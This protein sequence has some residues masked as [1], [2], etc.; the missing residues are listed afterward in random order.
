M[1]ALLVTM[2]TVAAP[3]IEGTI[4]CTDVYTALEPCTN[5]IENGGIVPPSCCKGVGGLVAQA[6]TVADRQQVCIC[7]KQM[8]AGVSAAAIANAAAIPSKCLIPFPYVISP[9][10]DCS[11]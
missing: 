2:L 3:A 4:T 7:L 9:S 10:T 11:K 6:N 5:Y 1:V 8:A